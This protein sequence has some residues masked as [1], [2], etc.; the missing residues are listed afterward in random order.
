M[1]VKSTDDKSLQRDQ[2]TGRYPLSGE[3]HTSREVRFT[4]SANDVA[5]ELRR[6]SRVLPEQCRAVCAP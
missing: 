2:V 5:M 4:L 6:H 1:E 3:K